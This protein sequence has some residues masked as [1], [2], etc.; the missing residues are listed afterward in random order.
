MTGHEVIC[1][2][3]HG[4]QHVWR[5]S[6]HRPA[7]ILH[8]DAYYLRTAPWLVE[9]HV[10][11]FHADGLTA[12]LQLALEG[13]VE[14]SY[15]GTP[16]ASGMQDQDPRERGPEAGKREEPA[17]DEAEYHQAPQLPPHANPS[18]RHHGIEA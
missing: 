8:S 15:P 17:Q 1:F 16:L 7:R 10:V 3:V 6:V 2:V 5:Q 18:Q 4:D 11:P 12:R 13:K 14:P 9:A